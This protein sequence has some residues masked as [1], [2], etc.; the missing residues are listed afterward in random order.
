MILRRIRGL[1]PVARIERDTGVGG[2]AY[3]QIVAGKFMIL[4]RI[5][6]LTPVARSHFL[7]IERAYS[8]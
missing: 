5:R 4:R 8:R 2:S 6:G 3:R 7:R 1:S